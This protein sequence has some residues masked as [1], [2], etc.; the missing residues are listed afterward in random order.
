MSLYG[1][2]FTD[3]AENIWIEHNITISPAPT[4]RLEEVCYHIASTETYNTEPYNREAYNTSV[5]NTTLLLFRFLL[6]T[7]I[8]F[9]LYM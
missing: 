7:V 6:L 8:R 1:S 2:S 3:S 9:F 5:Y 4:R